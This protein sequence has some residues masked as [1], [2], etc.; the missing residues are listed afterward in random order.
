MNKPYMMPVSGALPDLKIP[1]PRISKLMIFL[2]KVLGRVYLFLFYGVARVLLR[3]EKVLFDAFKRSLEG[4]SRCIIAFRHPNG[5]E[6]QFLTWFFLCKLKALAARSG[7]RFPRRPH[8]VFVYSYEVARWGGWVARFVMPRVGAMPIHHSKVDSQGMT[9]IYKAIV[10]GPFPL[11]LAPE[12]QVSYT[13]DSVP[14]LEQ[15]VIRIG[16]A[17]ADRMSKAEKPAPVEILPISVY[18][19]FGSWGKFTLELLLRKIEKAT[20]F[21]RRGKAVLPFAERLRVCRDHILAVNE[22]RYCI[23]MD[24]AL[25]FEERIDAVIVAALD[26]AE[27]IL[28]VRSSGNHF[29]R[30]YGL[31]QI[32]WDR[33]VLPGVDSLSN[34]S[35]IEREVTDLLAGEAWYAG[36]HLEIVDFSWYFRVPLPADD[37]SLHHKIEYA[38][39]LWDF[40][41]RTM[42]GAYANRISIFP[43]RVIIHAAPPINL[44]ERLPA[45]NND[46][47]SAINSAMADLKQAYMDCIEEIT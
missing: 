23:K 30:I 35:G 14:R 11:A 15:G 1:E 10:D 20:G 12:G 34:L 19:R 16:F 5:G 7:V 9:R 24:P 31:R 21:R 47:K 40:A 38:Q 8:A 39:N 37:A 45:Y 46:K 27:K 41:N 43:R 29:A 26:S 18:Y 6:P 25:S 42:G 13:T 3:G 36:R 32:C 2:I 28:G 17:A 33:I 22:K 44:T 4:K